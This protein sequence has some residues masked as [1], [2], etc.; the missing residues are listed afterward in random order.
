MLFR[1]RVQIIRR[2][3]ATGYASGRYAG[4]H[5][6]ARKVLQDLV[7]A[8]GDSPMRTNPVIPESLPTAGHPETLGPSAPSRGM[9]PRYPREDF[10]PGAPPV[11][12]TGSSQ[13]AKKISRDTREICVPS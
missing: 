13:R 4:G 7:R 5:A 3:K 12:R 11:M 8:A 2:E 10:T 1:S 6:H 9:Y